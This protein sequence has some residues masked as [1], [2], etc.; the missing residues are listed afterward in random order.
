MNCSNDCSFAVSQFLK[1]MASPWTQ[2]VWGVK[3]P[4]KQF[5]LTTEKIGWLKF[6]EK[7]GMG[8]FL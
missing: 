2:E 7:F 8:E 5:V 6:L 4:P 3:S 1:V